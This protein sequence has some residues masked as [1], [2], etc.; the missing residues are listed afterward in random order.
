MKPRKPRR[1]LSDELLEQAAHAC[2]IAFAKQLKT[3]RG[4]RHLRKTEKKS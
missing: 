2:G 3:A 1:I 4:L